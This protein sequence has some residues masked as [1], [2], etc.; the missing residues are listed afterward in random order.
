MELCLGTVQFGMDYGINQKK[1]P[2]EDD[3]VRWL[4]YAVQNGVRAIDT[5]EAYGDAEKVVG[6]FIRKKTI[7]RD[8]LF[9]STKM[10]PNTLD[11]CQPEMYVSVIRAHIE[12]SLKTIGTDYFDA[13]LFHSSRYAFVPALM[14]AL[15]LVQQAGLARNVGIS[16]YEPEEAF[17][18]MQ[19]KAMTFLQLP[20]NV[21][22]HRMKESGVFLQARHTG[23]C[24]HARSAFLQGLVLMNEQAVPPFLSRAK[25]IIAKLNRICRELE[26]RPAEL[27][28]SYVKEEAAVSHIVFGV[29]SL[30]QLQDN[31]RL[32][33]SES[34]GNVHEI[35]DAEFG[36]IAAD[37]V[38][39]SLWK[40]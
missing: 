12:Q 21:L 5:A 15:S 38:I 19:H 27:A 34:K 22:D 28:L 7:P 35:V 8:Q 10:M 2:P 9:L 40:K 31:I 3:C 26:M 23:I 17:A 14:D 29:H 20:Y 16:V 39:P 25:P 30:E 18:S 24:V 6:S 36:E 33:Y 4:D 32:F 37:I 11:D 1:R 13:Y